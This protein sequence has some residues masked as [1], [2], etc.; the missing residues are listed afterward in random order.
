MCRRFARTMGLAVGEGCEMMPIPI[1]FAEP[2]SPSDIIV[3]GISENQG[4]AYC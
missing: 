2:S 1:L 4:C 3:M